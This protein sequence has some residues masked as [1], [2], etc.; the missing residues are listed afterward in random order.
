MRTIAG[1]ILVGAVMAQVSTAN[2]STEVMRLP[3]N[4]TFVSATSNEP[5]GTTR[6]VGVTR[7]LTEAGGPQYELFY[8]ITNQNTGLDMEGMG[9]ISSQEFHVA[10]NS[11]SLD[12]DIHDIT[13]DFQRGELPEDGHISVEWV[14][15]DDVQRTAG[16]QLNF[17]DNVQFLFTGMTVDTQADITGTMFGTPLFEP[18]GDIRILSSAIIVIIH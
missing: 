11:A 18:S 5:D 10:P 12:V 15:T 6:Q 7:V 14:G 2:A 1:L 4:N 9:L 13:L 16:G 8:G 17:F 3:A